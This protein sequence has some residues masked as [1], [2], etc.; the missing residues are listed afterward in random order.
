VS[1]RFGITRSDHIMDIPNAAGHADEIHDNS[2]NM[3]QSKLLVQQGATKP[4]FESLPAEIVACILAYAVY[5]SSAQI[6]ENTHR[7][8]AGNYDTHVTSLKVMH[9]THRELRLL[10]FRDTSK[11]NIKLVKIVAQVSVIFMKHIDNIVLSD[12]RSIKLILDDLQSPNRHIWR[13]YT[14]DQL[15]TFYAYGG[16]RGQWLKSEMQTITSL[17]EDWEYEFDECHVALTIR[18]T[19]RQYFADRL[20]KCYAEDPATI[21]SVQQSTNTCKAA[22]A[23]G[24]KARL[25][26]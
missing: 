6:L 9:C 10:A 11:L 16:C 4:M 23:D 21:R 18:A 2:V 17:I 15:H 8:L 5:D 12:E 22:S 13:V 3:L 7:R 26:A 25:P 24:E 19:L 14:T 1:R 20:S